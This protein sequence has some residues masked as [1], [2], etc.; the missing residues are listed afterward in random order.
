MSPAQ[1]TAKVRASGAVETQAIR[2]GS[3]GIRLHIRSATGVDA[4]ALVAPCGVALKF[5]NLKC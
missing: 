5:V 3:W 2:R 4:C 1:R